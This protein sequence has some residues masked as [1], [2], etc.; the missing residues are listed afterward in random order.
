MRWSIPCAFAC[1]ILSIAATAGAQTE[2]TG[3]HHVAIIGLEWRGNVPEGAREILTTRLR[4]GLAAAAFDVSATSDARSCQDP[5]CYP[6]LA[7]SLNVGYLVVGKVEEERKTYEITVELVNGRTGSS[8]GSNHERCEICGMEDAAEKMGLAASALR[9]RLEAHVR[10]PARFIIRSRPGGAQVAL[11]GRPVG[12]TPFDARLVGG[13]HRLTLSA[14]GFDA[15]DRNFTV[16]SGVDETLEYEMVHVPTKFP[17][18]TAGWIAVAT[19]AVL[20][21]GGVLALV[22]D[23][24]ELACNASERDPQGDCPNLRSTRALGGILLGA[25]AVSATLGGV[26]I[27]FGSGGGTVDSPAHTAS[28][29]GG[30]VWRGVF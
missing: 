27:Y 19:G 8:I 15:L 9:A 23:S 12:R 16:V 28:S 30:V 5:S 29:G 7:Q 3:R 2:V 1:A 22:A 25:G 11:D 21:A 24:S 6:A 4:E 10:T 20:V 13:E 14:A 18:K 17:Y 26:W